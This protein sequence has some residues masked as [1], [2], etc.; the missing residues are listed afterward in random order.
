MAVLD[1]ASAAEDVG[2]L[3][4][5]ARTGDVDAW[6]ALYRRLYP[7]LYAYAGHRAGWQHAGDIVNETMARALAG[8]GRF[9]RGGTFDAWVFGITRNV[10]HEHHRS[11]GPVTPVADPAV[12]STDPP[13]DNAVLAAQD[14]AALR[15]AF[16]RLDHHDRELL[17]LRVVAGLTAREVAAVLHKRPGAVRMAQSRALAR[18]RVTLSALEHNKAVTR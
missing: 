2:E 12:T 4:E 6:D 18:L 3:V 17:E 7:R 14:R 5:R 11:Q 10:I 16:S 9:R 15:D 8:I 1:V 13:P